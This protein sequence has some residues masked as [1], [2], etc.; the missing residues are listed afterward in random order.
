MHERGIAGWTWHIGASSWEDEMLISAEAHAA[1]YASALTSVCSQAANQEA[2]CLYVRRQIFRKYISS[3]S[4]LWNLESCLETSPFL[5]VLSSSR[6]WNEVRWCDPVV[7]TLDVIIGIL[8]NV[9][10]NTASCVYQQSTCFALWIS[11][12]CQEQLSRM[13]CWLIPVWH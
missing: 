13:R 4:Q 3:T 7:L 10:S 11:H 8:K 1:G 9:M 5:C 6:V 12:F 2:L